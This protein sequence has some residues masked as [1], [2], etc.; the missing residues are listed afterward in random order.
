MTK[1]SI[2]QEI[3][4][5][6]FELFTE[7][8][9]SSEENYSFED[10]LAEINATIIEEDD[11]E[12]INLEN[13]SSEPYSLISITPSDKKTLVSALN[14]YYETLDGIYESNKKEWEIITKNISKLENM[15][16]NVKFQ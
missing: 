6:L 15:L 12:S 10:F 14:T 1:I 16:Q 4:I 11:T 8:Y 2:N 3:T 5:T 7:K 9:K 13:I